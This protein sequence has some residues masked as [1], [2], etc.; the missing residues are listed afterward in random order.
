MG[1]RPS[2]ESLGGA[3]AEPERREEY[4][5]YIYLS[6]PTSPSLS[7]YIYIYIYIYTYRLEDEAT[8]VRPPSLQS[9]GRRAGRTGAARGARWYIYI[10]THI[11]LCLYLSPKSRS[12]AWAAAHPP[13]PWAARGPSSSGA[14]SAAVYIYLHVYFY[15]YTCPLGV[16][17]VR[18][19]P[20]IRRIPGR[21]AGRTRAARGV[22]RRRRRLRA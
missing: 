1:C 7:L 9:P 8:H 14:R 22:R 10:P 12:S 13:N 6:I 11:C 20:P 15:V 2:A 21:R 4:I 19:L 17:V 3:Q 18:E 5:R 16:G